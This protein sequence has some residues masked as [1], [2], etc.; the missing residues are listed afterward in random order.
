MPAPVKRFF[1]ASLVYLALGLLAQAA[2]ILDVWWGF[3]PLAYTTVAATEQLLLV[4][5]LTQLGL[6]LAYDRWLLPAG[7]GARVAMAVLVLFNL[8]LP[9]ALAGQPGL[10]LFGRPWLG[11]A[12]A[13]GA[14]LQLVAGLLFVWEAWRA[15][16]KVR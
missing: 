10:A 3:N 2:A 6:A 13:A 5:W 1:I 12:A 15:L 7:A 8:G 16:R 9:L 14:A 11:A 4:G